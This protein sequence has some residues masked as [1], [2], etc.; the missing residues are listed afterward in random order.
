MKKP[1]K[2]LL[3]KFGVVILVFVI[4]ILYDRILSSNKKQIIEYD[5][6]DVVIK[7]KTVDH[8][9][10]TLNDSLVLNGLSNVIT[11]YGDTIQ[12]IDLSVPYRIVKIQKSE[13]LFLIDGKKDTLVYLIDE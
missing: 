8:G 2:I 1:D 5:T 10:L 6:I 4:F 11:K 7:N 12:I 9:F 3:V 13:L